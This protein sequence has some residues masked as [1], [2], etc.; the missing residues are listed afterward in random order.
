MDAA[1]LYDWRG[2][3]RELRNFVTRTMIMRDP[4][5]GVKELE[6]K[7]ATTAEIADQAEP[8]RTLLPCSGMR[9]IMRDVKDRTEAQLILDALEVSGWNRRHAAQYL[10]ISYR[11]L[12]Y[13]IQ[14][15]RLTPRLPRD[16]N[17]ASRIA[18]T[19]R[20]SST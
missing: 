12:L 1:L 8:E 5:S 9:T 2:N 15:H 16:S 4:D 20:G 3:L 19:V 17:G 6:A 7:I 18:H 14:Q 13:K 11:G 10:N